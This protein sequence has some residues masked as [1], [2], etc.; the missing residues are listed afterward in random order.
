MEIIQIFLCDEL[1][2]WA[3]FHPSDLLN[4]R[5]VL[6]SQKEFELYQAYKNDRVIKL[7][8]PEDK[9]NKIKKKI[10]ILSNWNKYDL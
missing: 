2:E 5:I 3:R 10:N 9:V 7:K 4:S 1:Q 8:L 6:K